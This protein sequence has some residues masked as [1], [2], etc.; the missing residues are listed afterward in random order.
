MTAAL[1]LYKESNV[2]MPLRIRYVN[3]T[4]TF[5]DD[6][7]AITVNEYTELRHRVRILL[8][9]RILSPNIFL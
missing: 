1:A 4:E 7:I 5:W 9:W 3:S 8:S 2:G 6:F